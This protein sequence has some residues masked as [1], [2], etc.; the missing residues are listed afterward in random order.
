MESNENI[1]NEPNN[2][3]GL[4]VKQIQNRTKGIK[5]EDIPY[6]KDIIKVPYELK[7]GASELL[8]PSNESNNNLISIYQIYYA[9]SF[10][11]DKDLI[12]EFVIRLEIKEN[13]K[14]FIDIKNIVDE[15]KKIKAINGIT[16]NESGILKNIYDY[17]IAK[18]SSTLIRKISPY[19]DNEPISA[20]RLRNY[21]DT[22]NKA[23]RE[24][25]NIIQ[26]EETEQ[27][28][29]VLSIC[30]KLFEDDSVDKFNKALDFI[31]GNCEPYFF[32]EIYN[33]YIKTD[34]KIKNSKKLIIVYDL[35]SMA[36]KDR[37]FYTEDEFYS[38]ELKISTYDTYRQN[39]IKNILQLK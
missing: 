34:L 12:N 1:T 13:E 5:K 3:L 17:V 21:R 2:E 27:N 15:I 6:L 39:V 19:K 33:D 24:N 37:I 35:F 28:E 25:R 38:S 26:N 22:K 36:I 16:V 7:R 10:S 29:Y 9:L 23:I 11:D 20:E 32:P 14:W 18:I 4:L 31:K 30:E 8:I